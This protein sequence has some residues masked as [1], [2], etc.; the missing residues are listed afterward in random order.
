MV[1]H[2]I[3]RGAEVAKTM[4]EDKPKKLPEFASN[5]E[6]V[7]FF[8]THDKGEYELE[9][10][11]FDYTKAKPNRFALRS[12]TTKQDRLKGEDGSDCETRSWSEIASP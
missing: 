5:E 1:Q 11:H 2:R 12:S 10:Y 3:L 6:F 4:T 9:E 8:E 7:E